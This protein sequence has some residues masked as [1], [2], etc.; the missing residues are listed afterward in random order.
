[1]KLFK[2]NHIFTGMQSDIS[3]SK[4]PENYLYDAQ[5]IRINLNQ[6]GN[7]LS[8]VNERGPL[9]SYISVNGNYLG[10][11]LIGKYLVV[12]STGD[13]D[14][15]TKIDLSKLKEDSKDISAATLRFKGIL[16]FDTDHPIETLA[17]YENENIQKVY[18]VD[19][20]NQPRVINITENT[21]IYST[22]EEY[23]AFDFVRTLKLNEY[24]RVRKILGGGGLFPSGVIQYAIT[25][26]DKFGQET[27]IVHTTPLQYISFNDRGG[28]P[29]EKINNS[30]EIFI[31]NVDDS[32]QFLRIYSILRTSL[33]GTP[34]CKRV[35]DIEIKKGQTSVSFVDTGTIGDNIDPTELLYKGGEQIAAKTIQDKNGTL[36]LGNISLTRPNLK[37]IEKEIKTNI[38]L[39]EDIRQVYTNITGG[40]YSYGNQL[41]SKDGDCTYPC[42]GFK[43]GDFYRCGVQF[44]YKTG[45]WSDPI[46]LQDKQITRRPGYS[47]TNGNLVL[48]TIKATLPSNIAS[49]L[50]QLGYKRV[51]AVVV[52]PQLKDRYV[53][54]QGVANAT[55]YTSYHRDTGPYGTAS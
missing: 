37:D 36:F 41:T 10:H 4:H 53:V 45:K 40:S 44:Q 32:F 30:F 25:Y 16:H 24:V 28:S 38:T 52:F 13:Y 39:G 2:D 54:C 27:N 42:G 18:W 29:E 47:S 50:M 21:T 31:N 22:N 9:L 23:T 12:F 43:T 20:K 26:Y 8:I 35:Q 1:M 55:S 48:P 17:S 3:I 49:Q 19:G 33:N 11:C 5:N 51:R 46:F 34:I 6:E 7:M 15:I 14:Y